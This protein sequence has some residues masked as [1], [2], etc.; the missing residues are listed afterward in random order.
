M[1]FEWLY[2]NGPHIR[3]P[4][5]PP[6]L[7]SHHCVYK[8]S[9]YPSS[10]WFLELGKASVVPYYIHCRQWRTR[11]VELSRAEDDLRGG[12]EADTEPV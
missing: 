5:W 6:A 2:L 11:K 8:S 7:G 4:R 9:K 1:N 3:T 12:T 10:W